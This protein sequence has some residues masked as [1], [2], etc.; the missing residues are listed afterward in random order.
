[1]FDRPV[2]AEVDE[3]GVDLNEF[4]RGLRFTA[5]GQA[6][7][8]ALARIEAEA[9]GAGPAPQDGH[10]N[11]HAARHQPLED[12]P[13]HRDADGL[14]VAFEERCDLALA[15]H[16]VVGADGFDCLDQSGGPLGLPDAFGPAR[17]RLG[18]FLPPVERRTGNAHGP[19]RLFGGETVRHRQAPAPRCVASSLRFDIGDLRREKTR[20]RDAVPDNLPGQAT[21]LHGGLLRLVDS[22]LS[23]SE[24]L[25]SFSIRLTSVRT[26]TVITNSRRRAS[27]EAN[28]SHRS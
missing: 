12:T 17:A 3:E 9:P 8:V 5:L 21:N 10:G 22:Q 26:R 7:G 28:R 23:A 25:L 18:R 15:P 1:M 14:S 13:D 27:C 2:G 16:R 24:T 19:R 11:D 6:L 20:R 4:T